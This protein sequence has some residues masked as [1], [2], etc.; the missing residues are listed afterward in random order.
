MTEGEAFEGNNESFDRLL[1]N[2]MSHDFDEP[3]RGPSFSFLFSNLRS[4]AAI[5]GL[6]CRV[7]MWRGGLGR[8]LVRCWLALS[9]ASVP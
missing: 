2:L 5:C 8:G 9:S 7:E 3:G 6:L 1:R 4:S